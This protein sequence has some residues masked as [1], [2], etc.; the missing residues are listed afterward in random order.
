MQCQ[1]KE[2]L[3]DCKTRKIVDN[4]LEKCK[5]LPLSLRVLEKVQIM[6][7]ALIAKDLEETFIRLLFALVSS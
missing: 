1:T 2:T 6:N 7:N 5:C 4:M 3:L